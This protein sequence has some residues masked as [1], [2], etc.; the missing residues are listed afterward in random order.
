MKECFMCLILF[1]HVRIISWPLF[2]LCF[3]VCSSVTTDLVVAY[4]NLLPYE[5][6]WASLGIFEKV[7]V[8]MLPFWFAY[9]SYLGYR[10][11]MN[12][13]DQ[14]SIWLNQEIFKAFRGQ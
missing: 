14:R 9:T 8:L 4:E 12:E 3:W 7:R 5:N 2:F 10:L 1:A 11:F 6:L 13:V